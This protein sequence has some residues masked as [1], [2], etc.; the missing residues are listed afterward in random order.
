M[1][2]AFCYRDRQLYCE[3]VPAEVLVAE[4]GTPLYVYSRT[5]IVERFRAFRAAFSAVDPLIAYSV[6]ANGNLAVLRLL[7]GE[8]AGADIVSAGELHRAQLAGIPPDRILFSG[9]GKTITE[10]AAAPPVRRAPPRP[11]TVCRTSSCDARSPCS[12]AAWVTP[13]PD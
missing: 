12:N 6:K 5:A 7:A 11:R 3:D 8:G 2:S 9:V 4:H 10:L 13:R 1:T